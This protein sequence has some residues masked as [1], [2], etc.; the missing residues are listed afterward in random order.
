VIGL[1]CMQVAGTAKIFQRGGE[2]T[3]SNQGYSPDCQVV[4]ATCCFLKKGLQKGVSWT[5]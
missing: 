1:L 2:V 5:P 3:L 4:L